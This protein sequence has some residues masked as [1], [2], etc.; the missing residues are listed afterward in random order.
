MPC[1][2]WVRNSSLSL[3]AIRISKNSLRLT[4][5]KRFLLSSQNQNEVHP[6]AC[7]DRRTRT[8]HPTHTF[9]IFCS[10]SF[11]HSNKCETKNIVPL[12]FIS[13]FR[14]FFF[15]IL[16]VWY[17]L[18]VVLNVRATRMHMK[19]SVLFFFVFTL[20]RSGVFFLFCF[21]SFYSWS[22]RR[23]VAELDEHFFMEKYFMIFFFI[24]FRSSQ[25]LGY[26]YT[27]HILQL[28]SYW[29]FCSFIPM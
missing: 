1:A 13:L 22:T 24:D 12:F 14:L 20:T 7:R 19:Y 29:K 23:G 16:S 25:F 15:H 4:K 26:M 3:L 6:T 18:T 10:P 9:F 27:M 21:R 11:A 17:A 2:G 8:R 28:T 5:T